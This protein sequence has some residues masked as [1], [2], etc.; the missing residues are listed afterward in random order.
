VAAGRRAPPARGGATRGRPRLSFMKICLTCV[1][2][3]RSVTKRRAGIALFE[4][5]SATRLNT[6]RSLDQGMKLE[7]ARSNVAAR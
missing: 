1:S 4:S 3:V 2:T 5:P 7:M 6:S